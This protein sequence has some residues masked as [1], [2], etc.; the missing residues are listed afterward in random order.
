MPH[1]SCSRV[2]SGSSRQ[3]WARCRR[4]LE[5]PRRARGP[6][7]PGRGRRAGLGWGGPGRAG[8]PARSRAESGRGGGLAVVRSR[9]RRACGWPSLPAAGARGGLTPSPAAGQPAG[10]RG[11]GAV[12]LRRS[13]GAAPARL[14]ASPRWRGAGLRTV[15]VALL[16]SV[17]GTG[18]LAPSP[19]L[20]CHL[21][22]SFSPSQS[23][24]LPAPVTVGVYQLEQDTGVCFSLTLRMCIYF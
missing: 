20:T 13:R 8:A 24:I 12:S 16:G 5:A 11:A 18:K 14:T 2:S 7:P 19:W 3:C 9:G 6:A 15:R 17:W 22:S 23:L 10:L 1:R 21:P 4:G